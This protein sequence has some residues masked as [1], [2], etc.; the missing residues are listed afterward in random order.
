MA[1]DEY[2]LFQ[3]PMSDLHYSDEMDGKQTRTIINRDPI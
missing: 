3:F 2:D 1:A